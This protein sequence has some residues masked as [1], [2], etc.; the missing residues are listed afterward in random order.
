MADLDPI[1]SK[2]PIPFN[3]SD[4]YAVHDIIGEGAYGVVVYVHPYFSEWTLMI[5]SAIHLASGTQVAIKR[6]NPFEHPMFIYRTLRE[7]KLLRHFQ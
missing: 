5:R 6:I 2:E 7:I 1:G 3:V 4:N